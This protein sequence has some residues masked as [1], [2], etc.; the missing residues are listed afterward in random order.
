MEV[1]RAKANAAVW[2]LRLQVTEESLVQYRESCHKLARVNEELTNQLY[3]AEKDTVDITGFFKRQDAAKEEK[4]GKSH[5][6]VCANEQGIVNSALTKCRFFF[7]K[8]IST[9]QK[10]LKSREALAREEQTKLVSSFK[11]Q[12]Q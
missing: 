7:F 3:R 10:S 6:F 9:L 5:Q 1:E 2:E 4:V 12:P 11:A 8:Q